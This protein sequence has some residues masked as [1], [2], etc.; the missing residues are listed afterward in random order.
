MLDGV[1]DPGGELD[2]GVV[3]RTVIS[4]GTG[5]G[6]APN[7]R[8]MTMEFTD[9]MLIKLAVVWSAALVYGLYMGFTG[10]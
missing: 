9:Y 10:Q 7:Y 5:M 6:N 2:A 3:D 1:S 8:V 4:D